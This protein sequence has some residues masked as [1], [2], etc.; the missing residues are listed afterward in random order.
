MK[1]I[2]TLIM[3]ILLTGCSCSYELTIENNKI[4]ESLKINGVK[5]EVP[6]DVDLSNLSNAN[7]NK[8]LK[9]NV[10]S[11]STDYSMDNYKNS[12]LLTCFDSYNIQ[13]TD[14]TYV[15]RT[16]KKFKCLPYQYNDFDLLNYEKLEIKI[17]T[18]HKVIKNN[19]NKVNN[20]TYYWFIDKNNI[21]NT[22][23]YFEIEK[24]VKNFTIEFLAIFIILILICGVIIYYIVKTKSEKNNK[25]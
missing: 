20:N 18:N 13:S 11:Y 16:G 21:D 9:E 5:T 15:I 2:L 8:E 7:Y 3:L 1:K 19:A 12:L 10:L 25:I 23:I 4:F 6:A 22:E 17:K 14:N 24:D